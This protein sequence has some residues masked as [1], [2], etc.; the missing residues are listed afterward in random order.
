[1]EFIQWKDSRIYYQRRNEVVL[2]DCKYLEIVR[3][4]K[5]LYAR[6]DEVKREQQENGSFLRNVMTDYFGSLPQEPLDV[7]YNCYGKPYLVG[8]PC[9][10]SL[11]HSGDLLVCAVAGEEIGVD[12]E[13]LHELKQNIAGKI[14]SEAELAEYEQVTE[15]EKNSRLIQMWTVKESIGKLLGTG[16]RTP[17][18]LNKEDY[19]L[20]TFWLGDSWVTAAKRK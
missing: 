4:K 10:F 6:K 11:S 3:Q 12:C 8:N 1:M 14:L 15:E 7:E 17:K 9:Y 16:I 20:H 19:M 5:I 2:C 18:E 13:K